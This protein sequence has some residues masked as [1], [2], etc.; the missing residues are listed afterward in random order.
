M[1]PLPF[2]DLNTLDLVSRWDDSLPMP[3]ER[4][5]LNRHGGVG[6]MIEATCARCEETFIPTDESDTEHIA[7]MDGSECGGF[8]E[9]TGEWS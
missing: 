8:G 3:A 5:G 7:R 6:M 1:T 4:G 9:I 2:R